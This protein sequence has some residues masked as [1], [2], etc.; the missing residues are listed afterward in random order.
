[1]TCGPGRRKNEFPYY[2]ICRAVTMRNALLLGAAAL[3][4]LGSIGCGSSTDV[5]VPSFTKGQGQT[6]QTGEAYP[7][8]PYG[9]NVGSVVANYHFVG[10]VNSVTDLPAMN[11]QEIAL[12]DF[13]NPDGTWATRRI[14]RRAPRTM[15]AS[16]PAGSIYGQGTHSEADGAAARRVGRLV[17]A[18]Q[19]RVAEHAAEA[20]YPTPPREGRP[21]L[22]GSDRRAEP[23]HAGD[24]HRSRQLDGHVPRGFPG[25]HRPRVQAR[26]AL[27]AADFYPA[28]LVVN[29]RNMKIC[30]VVSGAPDM[31]TWG[32]FAE[33]MAGGV[34]C[35]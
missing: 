25:R 9:I 22:A 13:Y 35:D 7:E 26:G 4:V 15:I 23:R 18:L 32:L 1:M 8:A 30:K 17:P 28:N 31:T 3:L 24:A 12:S 6:P 33:V 20:E 16:I 14:S 2:N 11:M 34:T 21:V 5:T 29:T 27:F 19:R 10:F